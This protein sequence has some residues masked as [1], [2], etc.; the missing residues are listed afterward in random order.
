MQRNEEGNTQK[1]ACIG[2]GLSLAEILSSLSYALDLTGGQPMGHAQRTCLIGMRIASELGL[3][4]EQL[5]SLFYALLIKDAGCSS[6][7]ARMYEIFGNDEIAAQRVSVLV[8]WSSR[9]DAVRHAYAHALPDASLRERLGR[10]LHIAAHPPQTSDGLLQA[11]CERGTQIAQALELDHASVQCIQH[12]DEHWDGNG[13]PNQVQGEAIPLLARIACLSQTLEVFATA[14]DVETA[15]QVLCKRSGQ[16]FDPEVVR[17]AHAFRYDAAFWRFVQ[18]TPS[19]ALLNLDLA[20]AAEMI[21][22]ERIDA[23]CYAFAQIV[24]AKSHFTAQHSSRVSVYAVEIAEAF[25]ITGRRLTTLR[26]AALLHDIGKLAV[27]NTI[28]DKPGKLTSRE[29][30]CVK[31]HPYYSEQV[32][33]RIANFQRMSEIAATHHERLDGSGYFRGL[34]AEQLDLDMRILAVADVF[35]ALSAERPYRKA[36]PLDN[37]FLILDQEAAERLDADCIAVV[38]Q[39]YGS[40]PLAVLPQGEILHQLAA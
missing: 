1:R 33:G 20:A 11:R 8:D 30:A 17:V 39:K 10:L 13:G 26:R 34:R 29:W 24:D 3:P 7:A 38:Q 21:S 22:E 25:G 37:V 36:L 12:L 9:L 35:D 4:L 27:P 5:D 32:L 16:W 14:L 6:N 23:V 15:Y 18:E 28:L 19:D 2:R 40:H 31:Q